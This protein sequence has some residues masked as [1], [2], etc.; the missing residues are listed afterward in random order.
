[1]VAQYEEWLEKSQAIFILSYTGL[2]NKQIERMRRA[3]RD[4][5]GEEI[6]RAHVWT[7]VKEYDIVCRLLLEKTTRELPT[8]YNIA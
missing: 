5:G 7:P 4:A 6:G 2:T 1:M 8:P 3:L